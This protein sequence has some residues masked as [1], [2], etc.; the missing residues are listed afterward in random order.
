MRINNKNYYFYL[1]FIISPIVGLINSI[2]FYKTG[3]YKNIIWL[4]VV[5]Y[6]YTI[7]LPSKDADIDISR[8]IE[9]FNNEAAH[10][11]Y[12]FSEFVRSYKQ[13]D[14]WNADFFEPILVYIVSRFFSDVKIM[15]IVYGLLFGFFYSRNIAC[16]LDKLDSSLAKKITLLLFILALINP[17][18]NINGF[19]FWFATHVYLYVLLPYFFENKKTHLFWLLIIPLIHFSYVFAVAIFVLYF[20]LGNRTQLFF[21]FFIIS[22]SFGKIKSN[23]LETVFSYLP[24]VIEKK[25]NGYTSEDYIEK[26]GQTKEVGMNWYA[27]FNSAY[28][29]Y[30]AIFVIILCYWKNRDLIKKEYNSLFSYVLF[31]LGFAFLVSSI[32]SMNRFITP[33]LYLFFSF[34]ILFVA[35]NLNTYWLKKYRYWTSFGLLICLVVQIRLGFDTISFLSVFT[36]PLIA[37]FFTEENFSLINIFK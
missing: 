23:F 5:F 15:F 3:S 13:D 8:R 32:P 4:F 9:S 20:I 31:F 19:R 24:G 26:I 35:N 36:N 33:G 27:T 6:S 25:A 14:N 2:R 34:Y 37:P 12:K 1:L 11:D 29:K 28:L 10:T 7:T 22:V 16:I 30:F 17:F 21:I 18:W